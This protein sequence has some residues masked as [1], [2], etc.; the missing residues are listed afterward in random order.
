MP[1]YCNNFKN[2]ITCEGY[3]EIE[4]VEYVTEKN[5]LTSLFLC[6][7]CQALEEFS[8]KKRVKTKIKRFRKTF[9]LD[10][11]KL[12]ECI[13]KFQPVTIKVLAE[14]LNEEESTVKNSCKE[15][16]LQGKITVK[17]LDFNYYYANTK[18]V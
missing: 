9:E 14:K 5:I 11:D 8:N 1:G 4:K 16:I 6:K 10:K 3:S 7:S 13:K 17:K 18:G 12:F 2:N 15:L